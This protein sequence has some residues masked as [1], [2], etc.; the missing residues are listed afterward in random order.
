TYSRPIP[1][2]A[3]SVTA[4]AQSA[5][6]LNF[7]V[8]ALPNTYALRWWHTFMKRS[9]QIIAT[10]RHANSSAASVVIARRIL[11]AWQRLSSQRRACVAE[12]QRENQHSS[13]VKAQ[14]A[15]ALRVLPIS[16]SFDKAFDDG[17]CI[18]PLHAHPDR[19]A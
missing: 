17:H 14:M 7:I 6:Q 8:T 9:T 1:R 18:E 15:R 10:G 13:N 5:Y 2:P 3:N 19:Q 16:H 11:A 4:C 12:I